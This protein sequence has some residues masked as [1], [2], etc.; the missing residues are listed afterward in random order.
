MHYLEYDKIERY[1]TGQT[2]GFTTTKAEWGV[3]SNFAKTPMLVNGVQFA[4]QI[5]PFLTKAT[6]V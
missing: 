6:Y 3:L 1:P 5:V 2:V 4:P